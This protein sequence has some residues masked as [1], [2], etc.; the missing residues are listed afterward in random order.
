MSAMSL[1]HHFFNF[2]YSV[3]NTVKDGILSMMT[4]LLATKMQELSVDSMIFLISSY[5][6]VVYFANPLTIIIIYSLLII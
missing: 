3:K 5:V 4:K 6:I 2:I 1:T